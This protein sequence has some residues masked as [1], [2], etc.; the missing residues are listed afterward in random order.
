MLM[1]SLHMYIYLPLWPNFSGLVCADACTGKISCSQQPPPYSLGLNIKGVQTR[2][3]FLIAPKHWQDMA[4]TC[5]SGT[6]EK[7]NVAR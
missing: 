2:I 4:Y 5:T 6:V 3:L 7:A 1:K